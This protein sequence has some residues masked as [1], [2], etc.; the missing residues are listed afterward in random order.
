[1]NDTAG[2]ARANRRG[3]PCP[4][5]CTTDHD[6]PSAGGHF[7]DFHG[8]PAVRTEIP[9]VIV[10]IPDWI[11]VRPVSTGRPGDGEP[12]VSVTGTVCTWIRPGDAED[13]A[14]LIEMLGRATPDQHAEVAA[15]IRQAAAQITKRP[16]MTDEELIARACE[17]GAALLRRP[18]ALDQLAG[19]LLA[20]LAARL[21][22]RPAPSPCD[23]PV[24]DEEEN[25]EQ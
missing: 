24:P 16:A 9:G 7:Y 14:G 12:N 3:D 25:D 21:A 2:P 13:I 1:M 20:E 23:G 19:G 17:A 6:T 15:A 22:A 11:A 4:S 18:G 10:S 5:W 8:G